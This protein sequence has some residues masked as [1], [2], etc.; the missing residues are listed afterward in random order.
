MLEKVV[1]QVSL[2]PFIMANSNKGSYIKGNT[3]LTFLVI[4]P[5]NSLPMPSNEKKEN[6]VVLFLLVAH[7]CVL[8]ELC[9]NG[10]E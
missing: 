5:P 6:G 10:K 7:A 8:F 2:G 3:E 9:A 1:L 4:Q